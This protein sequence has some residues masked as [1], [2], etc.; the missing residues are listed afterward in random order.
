MK[1]ISVKINYR[2]FGMND[3]QLILAKSPGYTIQKAEKWL[4]NS[5]HCDTVVVY[6]IEIDG[7]IILNTGHEPFEIVK[8]ESSKNYN[9][10]YLNQKANKP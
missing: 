3:Q 9:T 5:L 10:E 1:L 4:R 8:D 6:S 2:A 7:E